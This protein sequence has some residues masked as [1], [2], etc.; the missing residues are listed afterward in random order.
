ME[1]IPELC[2]KCM[3][4]FMKIVHVFSRLLKHSIFNFSLQCMRDAEALCVHQHREGFL[5]CFF[6]LSA[7]TIMDI[8]LLF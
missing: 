1:Y 6:F 5:F 2:H 3:L 7:V 8:F 4:N